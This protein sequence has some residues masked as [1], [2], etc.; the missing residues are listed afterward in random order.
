MRG[1]DDDDGGDEND[2]SS[3]RA[4]AARSDVRAA[5]YLMMYD[6]DARSVSVPLLPCV[7]CSGGGIGDGI[8]NGG[9]ADDDDDGDDD[10][11]FL[12][13][14]RDDEMENASHESATINQHKKTTA[15]VV[16]EHPWLCRRLL[17][18]LL[19]WRPVSP[20]A[21]NSSSMACWQGVT[22]PARGERVAWTAIGCRRFIIV[23]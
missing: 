5:L 19:F 2:S 17:L 11:E 20:R 21:T 22:G 1:S 8:G 15:V 23:L 16:A 18:Y 4:I 13:S 12:S 9:T 3:N 7:D 10:T 14:E 6:D